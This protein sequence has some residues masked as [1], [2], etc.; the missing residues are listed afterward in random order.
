MDAGRELDSLTSVSLFANGAN[1]PDE[2]ALLRINCNLGTNYLSIARHM[3]DYPYMA[4]TAIN[5]IFMY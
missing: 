1:K 5:L 2:G 3:A 4:A